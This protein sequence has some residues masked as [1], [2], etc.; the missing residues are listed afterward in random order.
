VSP[1]GSLD[2]RRRKGRGSST[3]RCRGVRPG[4]DG[5][6]NVT[7]R[8]SLDFDPALLPCWAAKERR[9]AFMELDPVFLARAQ[10]AFTISFHILFP[11]LTIGLSGFIFMLEARWLRTGRAEYLGLAKFWSRLFALGFGMGV[12]SGV[13]LS[14]QF[15]TNFSRF[16]DAVSNVLGPLLGYE[17]LT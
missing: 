8:Q 12:V 4:A 14:Y 3:L 15:G 9:G 17:V 5:R 11:R 16:S 6:G 13:V 10:F 2:R 1:A 7:H